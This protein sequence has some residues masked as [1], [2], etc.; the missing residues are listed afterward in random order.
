MQQGEYSRWK[1]RTPMEGRFQIIILQIAIV[2]VGL[3]PVVKLAIKQEEKELSS[4]EIEDILRDDYIIPDV[5]YKVPKHR[6][7]VHFEEDGDIYHINY[8][9]VLTPRQARHQPKVQWPVEKD[10]EYTLLCLSPDQPD[11]EEPILRD[12]IH[13][14]QVN[15]KGCNLSTGNE[16]NEYIGPGPSEVSGMQRYVFLVY[17]QDPNFAIQLNRSD[18]S[19]GMRMLTKRMEF[20]TDNFVKH[21]HLGDPWASNYFYSKFNN[22]Q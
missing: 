6:L 15:I 17:K 10:A 9:T 7:K 21:F 11:R 20:D 18:K 14:Q 8:G 16:V 13:W 1:L 3:L 12:W 2:A 5:I 4:K 19:E 22:Y